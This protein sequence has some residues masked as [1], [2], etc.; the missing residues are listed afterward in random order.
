MVCTVPRARTRAWPESLDSVE[1]TS[2]TRELALARALWA[3]GSASGGPRLRNTMP[4]RSRVSCRIRIQR[5][6]RRPLPRV[7]PCVTRVRPWQR[8]SKPGPLQP[9][10]AYS[11]CVKHLM[12]LRARPQSRL[13]LP[14]YL[15]PSLS[16]AMAASVTEGEDC[17]CS[18]PPLLLK[19]PALPFCLPFTI[20][21]L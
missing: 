7:L 20:A 14:F 5:Q 15:L 19:H 18:L 4:S 9:V 21:Q 13:P 1:S 11:R 2:C 10:L 3:V 8:E 6:P 12:R 17:R 16:R